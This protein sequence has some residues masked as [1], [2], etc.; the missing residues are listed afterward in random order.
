[1]IDLPY[2]LEIEATEYP[3]FFGFHSPDLVGFT[4]IGHSVE[5]CRDQARR[6]M[7]EHVDLLRERG[8]PVPP[9]SPDPTVMIRNS[10]RRQTA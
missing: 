3:M 1:M 8:L 2:S 5:D 9:T 10:P 4:G 7:H 6:G